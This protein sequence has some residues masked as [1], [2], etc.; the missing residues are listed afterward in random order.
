MDTVRSRVTI[1]SLCTRDGHRSSRLWGHGTTSGACVSGK[2]RNSLC[3]ARGECGGETGGGGA[4]S[5]AVICDS[6]DGERAY[7]TRGSSSSLAT[8]RWMWWTAW[9][10]GGVR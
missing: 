10:C 8:C 7:V 6:S 9:S 5:D 1:G 4:A 3:E 2:K